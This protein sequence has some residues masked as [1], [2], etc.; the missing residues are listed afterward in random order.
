MQISD[1]TDKPNVFFVTCHKCT[2]TLE[3][4][5]RP[6]I[7]NI[8]LLDAGWVNNNGRMICPKCPAATDTTYNKAQEQARRARRAAI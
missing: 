7:L 3:V 6:E 5:G 4:H 8:R 1:S 2:R